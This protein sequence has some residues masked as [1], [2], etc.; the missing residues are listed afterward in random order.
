MSRHDPASDY[1]ADGFHY[2]RQRQAG[3]VLCYRTGLDSG[4][5]GPRVGLRQISWVERC[6]HRLFRIV[7]VLWGA[8]IP[9]RASTQWLSLVSRKQAVGCNF[10]F[11][12]HGGVL[13][14]LYFLLLLGRL[15]RHIGNPTEWPLFSSSFVQVRFLRSASCSDPAVAQPVSSRLSELHEIVVGLAD[16]DRSCLWNQHN[17]LSRP[18]NRFEQRLPPQLLASSCHATSWGTFSQNALARYSCR[19]TLTGKC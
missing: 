4:Q 7:L 2:R 17:Q 19:P 9:D 16:I 15:H 6:R 8:L 10:S 1:M 11:S 14:I 3:A 18:Q 13:R 5:S 12:N